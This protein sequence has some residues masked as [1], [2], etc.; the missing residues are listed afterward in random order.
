MEVAKCTHHTIAKTS[1][2]NTAKIMHS[3]NFSMTS[4]VLCKQ[5]LLFYRNSW[6]VF[7]RRLQYQLLMRLYLCYNVH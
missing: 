3:E 7:R 6:H 5:T 2:P 1:H 4:F